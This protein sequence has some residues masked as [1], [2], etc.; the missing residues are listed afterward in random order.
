MTDAT[1]YLVMAAAALALYRL[2]AWKTAP[3]EVAQPAGFELL[4]SLDNIGEELGGVFDARPINSAANERAFLRMIRVAEGTSGPLGYQ[5]LFGH[6]DRNPK[7]FAS[8]ADHP[9]I[10]SQFTDAKR[11]RLW[12]SAAGAFQAMAVS[13]I[14]GG[15]STRVDT[16]DRIKRR[17][18]LTDFSPANQDRFA[19]ALI[20][21]AGALLDVQHGRF[22]TAVSKV[23]KIWASLPGAGYGQPERNLAALRTA[24]VQAGGT[25]A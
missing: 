14:P 9:R 5:A 20:D 1:A 11:G 13:P 16:W 23:R 4:L 6:T 25:L 24:Y 8:W 17:H 15:G 7:V 2:A 19:L 10:A 21:E 22:D 18:N 3:A 12:T